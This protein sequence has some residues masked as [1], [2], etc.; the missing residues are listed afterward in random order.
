MNETERIALVEH[1][2]ILYPRLQQLFEHMDQCAQSVTEASQN[3]TQYP[4][5]MAV[6]GQAGVGKTVL[7]QIWLS[8]AMR[9]LQVGETR[10]SFVFQR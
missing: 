3:L 5:N 10:P 1:I 9:K 8:E 4:L 7:A 6:A 2:R